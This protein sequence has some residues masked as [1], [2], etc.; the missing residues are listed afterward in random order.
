MPAKS[1][2]NKNPSI[3]RAVAMFLL[4]AVCVLK[5]LHEHI[6]YI[7]AMRMKCENIMAKFEFGK[8]TDAHRSHIRITVHVTGNSQHICLR[9]FLMPIVFGKSFWISYDT[10]QQHRYLA[11]KLNYSLLRSNPFYSSNGSGDNDDGDGADVGGGYFTVPFLYHW[12]NVQTN[13][14]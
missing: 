1:F 10:K 11:E 6:S 7:I 8:S 4:S 2:C 12:F 9:W 5:K 3:T 14:T 13:P